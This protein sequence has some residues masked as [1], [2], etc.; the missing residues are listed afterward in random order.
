MLAE[1]DT[2]TEEL[3]LKVQLLADDSENVA[4]LQA[5]VMARDV[6]LPAKHVGKSPSTKALKTM[7]LN[8]VSLRSKLNTLQTA[9]KHP[10]EYDAG[11]CAKGLHW[12]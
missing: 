5:Q 3:N 8:H 7:T 12:L 9:E 11:F 1:R 2:K 6:A 4:K 10:K